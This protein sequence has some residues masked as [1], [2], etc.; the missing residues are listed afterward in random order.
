M[1][2]YIGY[3]IIISVFLFVQ[4]YQVKSSEAT[5]PHITDGSGKAPSCGAGLKCEP[6]GVRVEKVMLFDGLREVEII[7]DCH[8]EA[9]LSQC[10]RVPALKTFN[11]E[12]P[13][14]TVVDVG[15]CAG[16]KAERGLFCETKHTF[17]Q[18]T[19]THTETFFFITSYVFDFRN[20][21][22][23]KWE[24]LNLMGEQG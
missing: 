13:Y 8:C 2:K 20:K 17:T 19:H 12:T 5:S 18:N 21:F 16:S 4:L 6:T 23:L 14:E 7:E 11:F 10:M 3:K 1:S 24:N 15:K 22:K 9:A